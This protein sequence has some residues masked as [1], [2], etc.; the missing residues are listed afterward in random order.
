M[1]AYTETEG[2]PG[3]RVAALFESRDGAVCSVVTGGDLGCVDGGRVRS[4][5]P[6]FP[7][8]ITSLGWGWNQIVARDRD[9]GWWLTSGDGL[10]RYPPVPDP[11]DLERTPVTRVYS[12]RDGLPGDYVFRVFGD[13]RGDVWI[14]TV[15][16]DPAVSIARW[17]R[18]EGRI[19]GFANARGLPLEAPTAFAEDRQGAIWVGFYHGGVARFRDDQFEFFGTDRGCPAG[20]VRDLHVDGRGGVWVATGHAG[21]AR[22]PD[23]TAAAPTFVRYG[24]EQGLSS[25]FVSCVTEDVWGRVYFGTSRGLDRLDPESGIVRHFSLSDGLPNSFVNVAMRDRQGALWFGT[26]GGMAR[27]EPRRDRP[28]PPPGVFISGVKVAGT[29]WPVSESGE[30]TTDLAELPPGSSPVEIEF[31]AP[32]GD[33]AYFYRL[34]GGGSEEWAGPTFERAV[35]LANLSPGRYRFEVK[36][37]NAEGVESEHPASVSLTILRPLWRRG[38]FIGLLVACTVVVAVGVYRARIAGLRRHQAE[39]ARQVADRTRDLLEAK[40]QLEDSNRTLEVR[41]RRGIEAL[42]DAERMAAYGNLVSGV[43]HEVRHPIFSLQAAAYV[44]GD[45]LRNRDDLSAQLRIL[46]RETKRM[47]ALMDD[48]LEF[49]RPQE[50]SPEET[51]PVSLLREADEVFRSAGAE[52]APEVEVT[53]GEALPRVHVDRR[54]MLQVFVNLME[55]ARKHAAGVTTITLDARA[56]DRA[57]AVPLTVEFRVANDG[58]GIDEELREQIF[59]PFYTSGRGTGLGLAIVKRVVADHGG[60]IELESSDRGGSRF[61]ISIP[62]T[63]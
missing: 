14:G 56:G 11:R 25:D 17:R 52:P 1:I 12:S 30:T 10:L 40:R 63:R 48:L 37:V 44:L 50:L 51:D 13:S 2:L 49:A 55:N 18:D 6:A 45:K 57:G 26:L 22:I 39:L 60:T 31:V 46:D 62:A 9:G 15:A 16:P 7:D 41:V 3:R 61:T 42:R 23:P 34:E 19:E 59:E 33:P 5:H 47:T 43:A 32:G 21:V 29:A 28:L 24:T 38:W 27:L 53:H 20:F 58:A 54:R 4:F 35:H 8:G 36:A